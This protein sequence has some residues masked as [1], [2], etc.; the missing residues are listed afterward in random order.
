MKHIYALLVIVLFMSCNQDKSFKPAF[1]NLSKV[2][3]SIS[4][5]QLK[6][7]FENTKKFPNNTQL[8][9]ALIKKG[10]VHFLGTERIND[11]ISEKRNQKRVFEIGS[12][13]K[14]FTATI[15]SNFVINKK[16]KI[17]DAINNFINV[18]IKNN[19]KISFKQLANHTSGLPKMPS[20][21]EYTDKLNKFKDYNISK[22]E[23]YI[24]KELKTSF[25][26]GQKR[27]YSNIGV[28]ILGYTL[29]KI[30]N[31]NYEQLLN[32]YITSKFNMNFTTQNRKLIENHLI[33]GLN[34]NGNRTPNWDLSSLTPA[35]GILSN[36]ED[37]SKFTLA[38]FN[39]EN[40]DLN[41]TRVKTFQVDKKTSIGLGWRIE[42]INPNTK[43]F[44]HNGRTGGYTSSIAINVKKKNGVIILSNISSIGN[45]NKERIE[46]L[47]FNLLKSLSN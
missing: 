17:D 18:P 24:T 39:N 1:N 4:L 13:S 28:G 2:I 21:L 19:V 25:N 30:S 32:T 11:T 3:D 35:G 40:L 8:S 34:S 15:L 29:C 33:K 27:S 43:W 46:N 38:Q 23:S 36:V 47:C 42:T 37:L 44:C 20:N 41:L 12:L 45:G 14:I 26:P 7:V 31:K 16:I 6:L 22:L 5:N 9:I 10:K